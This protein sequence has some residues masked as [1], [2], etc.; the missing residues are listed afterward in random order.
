MADLESRIKKQAIPNGLL[1]GVIILVFNIFSFY[2][3]TVICKNPIAILGE[4]L[5]GFVVNIIVGV[6]F[7]LNL[8]KKVGGY[9]TFRQATSGIFIMFI[10]S[11][12]T[13]FIGRDLIFGKL[14]EPNMIEKTQTAML[15]A[16]NKV[17]MR[18]GVDQA[19]IDEQDETI[20]KQLDAEKNMTATG[21]VK[22][23][24]INFIFLFVV[25]AVVAALFKKEPPLFS[26]D[27]NEPEYVD[28]TA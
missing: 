4:I 22:T 6:L 3:I 12:L 24:F 26:H 10:I 19:K 20:H 16:R 23:V 8:R 13:L 7:T 27:V 15:D 5:L 2:F 11:Y 21:Y 9:W 28:P 25:S 1:L 14:V 18:N 17:L